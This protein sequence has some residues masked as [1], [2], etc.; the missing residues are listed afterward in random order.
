MGTV[1][2][3]HVRLNVADNVSGYDLPQ[4]PVPGWLNRVGTETT[5]G[6]VWPAWAVPAS[7]EPDFGTIPL[8]EILTESFFYP[9]CGNDGRLLKYTSG[10]VHSFVH[11]DLWTTRV[12]F[13]AELFGSSEQ[14]RHAGLRGYHCILCREFDF[15]DLARN[16]GR[17]PHSRRAGLPGMGNVHRCGTGEGVWTV[18]QRNPDFDDQHGPERLSLLF[19]NMDACAFYAATYNYLCI[20]PFVVAF[21]LGMCS[22]LISELRQVMEAN[23]VG[24]PFLVMAGA[25]NHGRKHFYPF[26]RKP[27]WPDLYAETPVCPHLG[28]FPVKSSHVPGGDRAA[29]QAVTV[30]WHLTEEDPQ[31]RPAQ[32]MP[33][34]CAAA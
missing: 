26:S 33:Q 12:T 10:F 28:L 11:V 1:P 20:R 4:R 2:F 14:G 13:L 30:P 34:R 17:L 32:G 15:A 23:P 24:F 8:R 27:E 16:Q 3:R 19:I 9:G 22:H 25:P 31:H 29:W 7:D 5:P 21:F 6:G 18:W